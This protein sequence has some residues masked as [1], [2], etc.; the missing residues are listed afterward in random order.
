MTLPRHNPAITTTVFNDLRSLDDI[1]EFNNKAVN[2][3]QQPH[4][5]TMSKGTRFLQAAIP[6]VILYIVLLLNI[7]PVPFV[8]KEAA[9]QVLPVVSPHELEFGSLC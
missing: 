5:F 4:S 1:D 9:D 7:L 3:Y 8:S 6:T 2:V